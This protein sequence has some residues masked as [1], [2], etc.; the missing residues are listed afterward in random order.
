MVSISGIVIPTNWDEKG[1]VV[2]VAIATHEEEDYFVEE[3]EQVARLKTF[4]R[5]EV[6]VSGVLRKEGSKK[7]IKIATISTSKRKPN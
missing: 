5:Q 7:I 2:C 4:L 6:E 1:N 3:Y